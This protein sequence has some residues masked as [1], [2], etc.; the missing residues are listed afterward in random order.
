[1]PIRTERK[2][3]YPANWR[4]EIVPAVRER[5]GNRCEVCG[6]LNGAVITRGSSCGTDALQWWI[7]EGSFLIRSQSD[8]KAFDTTGEWFIEWRP[9]IM[10][11]LTVAHLN[12][13]EAD[14]RL[15][16]LSHLCQLHHNR[17][18]A[19]HRASGRKA[20]RLKEKS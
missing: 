17:H 9:P 10:V 4:S 12:H 15:E 18:D 16:N 6:V 8:G 20:R 5:S 19:T 7:Y 14:N 11:V 2:H 13:D 1:M 3:L